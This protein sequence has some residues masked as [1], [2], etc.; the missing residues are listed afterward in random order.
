MMASNQKE[1]INLY[2]RISSYL[3]ID[4]MAS[5]PI[6]AHTIKKMEPL[7]KTTKKLSTKVKSHLA[8]ANSKPIQATSMIL[9]EGENLK[10]HKEFH[11]LKIKS[12]LKENFKVIVVIQQIIFYPDHK[13]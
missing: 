10:E 11:C 2:I 5:H 9:L 12:C 7:P 1:S 8:T 3:K 4:S 13:E 6:L